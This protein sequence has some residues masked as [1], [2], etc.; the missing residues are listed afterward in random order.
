MD[1]VGDDLPFV[2]A[3]LEHS[4]ERLPLP[5]QSLLGLLAIRNVSMGTYESARFALFISHGKG[6]CHDPAIGTVFVTQAVL[7]G[8]RG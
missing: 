3:G 6:V 2:V 1:L 5:L 4:P 8:N 7:D